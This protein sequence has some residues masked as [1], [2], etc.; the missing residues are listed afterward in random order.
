[1]MTSLT[2][3]DCR[4]LGRQIDD[5]LRAV[6]EANGLTYKST[7]GTIE[8]ASFRPKVTFTLKT[9]AD[10]TS[11]ERFL[12][13]RYAPMFDLPKSA[14]GRTITVNREDW[15]VVALHPNRPRYPLE[16][17]RIRTGKTM[18]F[19]ESTI[20]RLRRVCG[21]ITDVNDERPCASVDRHHGRVDGDVGL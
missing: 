2:N 13:E 19:T 9:R 8:G 21:G 12:F 11:V 6:A 15:V 5:A 18:L 3:N 16:L 4:N 14:Y 1:M 10:G 20:D 7:G 17:R